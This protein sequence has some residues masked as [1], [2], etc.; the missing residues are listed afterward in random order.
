MKLN[1]YTNRMIKENEFEINY[2]KALSERRLEILSQKPALKE[3]MIWQGLRKNFSLYN[4]K[5]RARLK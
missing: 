3:D 1:I 4:M 5:L 2:T